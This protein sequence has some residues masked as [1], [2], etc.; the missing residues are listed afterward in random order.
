MWAVIAGP[1]T[2]IVAVLG[3]RVQARAEKREREKAEEERRALDQRIH[4]AMFGF[5][6]G[7]TK[8]RG[9]VEMLQ[10]NGHG[11]LLE[12][13]EQSLA[14]N[15]LLDDRSR[16]IE[17]KL[18]DVE[19][20]AAEAVEVAKTTAIHLAGR[21]DGTAV[22]LAAKV[23]LTAETLASKVETT[24]TDLAT[25][26]TETTGMLTE[27]IGAVDEKLAGHITEDDAFREDAARFRERIEEHLGLPP[28]GQPT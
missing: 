6:E 12:M 23:E 16:V 13:V 10:G 7:A 26:V 19:T 8:V 27:Q 28:V 15:A 17:T 21:V 9:V 3:L 18:V 22:E 14:V 4:D 25:T 11:D 20:A 2:A 5:T 1:I 24:A